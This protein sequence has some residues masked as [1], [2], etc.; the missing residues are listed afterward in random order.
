MRLHHSLRLT[1]LLIGCTLLIAACGGSPASPSISMTTR[2]STETTPSPNN[3]TTSRNAA[4]TPPSTVEAAGSQPKPRESVVPSPTAESAQTA[5]AQSTIANPTSERTAGTKIAGLHVEGNKLVKGPGQPVQLRGVNHSGSEYACIQ[6]W[7]FF[8]GP[9]DAA[10][11]EA[12]ARWRAN[13]VR[14]PLNET[15]WLGINGAPAQYSGDNYRKEIARYVKLL[16]QHGLIAILDLHWSAP[17]DQ[18]ATELQ[19]MPNRDHSIMFW[20]QVANTFKGDDSAIFDLF[21]EPWPDNNEDSQAAWECWK[22]GG[23]CGED[24]QGG[25]YQ[26]AGMQE[27]V[28]AVRST[29]A[30]N[31][32]MLGGVQYSNTLSRWLEYKPNDP[33]KNLAASW[34]VYSENRCNTAGCWDTTVAPVAQQAPLVAGEIGDREDNCGPEFTRVVMDWLDRQQAGYLPW[35]WNTWGKC[36]DLIKNYDGTPTQVYGQSIKNHFASSPD[37]NPA[38]QP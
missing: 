32:I 23:D 14:V 27:L 6:G 8:D 28:D 37:A 5:A 4:A 35:V 7:G 17:G 1:A 22:N 21:N 13:A 15:C 11:V 31:V 16:G 34:H 2:V 20:K 12:I 33:L 30:K 36:T 18:K 3:T 10:S 24:R 25:R 26:A 19:S 38:T 29:G 9:T